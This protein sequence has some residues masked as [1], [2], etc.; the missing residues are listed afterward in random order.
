RRGIRHRITEGFQILVR[1]VG[2]RLLDQ[3]LPLTKQREPRGAQVADSDHQ[4]VP[5]IS[6]EELEEL[7]C[8]V[9]ALG[10]LPDRPAIGR[11]QRVALHWPLRYWS[12]IP[13][14]LPRRRLDHRR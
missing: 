4:L 12:D 13:L 14:I 11:G 10:A 9:D 7:P 2:H 5:L 3:A 6:L 8:V 1:Q